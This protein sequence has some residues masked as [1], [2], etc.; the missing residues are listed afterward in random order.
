MLLIART[1]YWCLW[2]GCFYYIGWLNCLCGRGSQLNRRY[3]Q[4]LT[5]FVQRASHKTVPSL[6]LH[7]HWRVWRCLSASHVFS[8]LSLWKQPICSNRSRGNRKKSRCR[9]FY[10]NTRKNFF[11]VRVME[12][13]N[14]MW[15]YSRSVLPPTCAT[16]YKEPPSAVGWTQRSPEI[17]SKPCSSE[18]LYSL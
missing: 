5:L 4:L 15:R 10:I 17:P 18:I 13:W 9:N 3:L 16:C 14:R 6:A 2:Q 7:V 12:H 1:E 8:S 11:T